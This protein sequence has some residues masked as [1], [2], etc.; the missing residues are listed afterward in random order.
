VQLGSGILPSAVTVRRG[1]SGQLALTFSDGG[2]LTLN[3]QYTNV[4]AANTAGQVEQVVFA[5]GTVWD[6]AQL[7]VL[8]VTGGSGVDA[9]N[10]FD[11]ADV[12]VGG[13]GN[14]NM[15]GVA[16]DDIYEGGAGTDTLTDS[17]TTSNE[18]YRYSLG[19]GA[20]TVSDSGG[21]DTVQLG[22][23]ILPSA[24]TVRRGTSGQLALTFS[25]GGI[26]TLNSQYSNVGVANTA[27]QIEQVVFADGTVW[28][29]AQLRVLAVAG[30]SAVDALHGFDGAD[31]LTG[32]ASN[33][34][35]QGYAGNDMLDGGAGNDTMTGGAGDDTYIV[36]ST[37]DTTT[38]SASA[39]TD[40]VISSVT[41]TSGLAAN[42]ENLTLSGANAI[43]GTGNALA[44]TLIGNAAA[45]TL[46]GLEGADV[47][48][49][50]AGNDT[51]NDTSTTSNDTYRFGIGYGLDTITDAG[52]TD[53]VVFGEG[54]TADQISFAASGSHLLVSVAG[55]ADVL[56]VSNWYASTA[57]RIEEFRLSDGTLLSADLIPT[58]NSTTAT[59]TSQSVTPG[60]T[61]VSAA[62]I[63]TASGGAI[64]LAT[65]PLGRL[66]A[67][68]VRNAVGDVAAGAAS[69]QLVGIPG[70]WNVSLQPS[71]QPTARGW[72]G[73][74][75]TTLPVANGP[76][77]AAA[78]GAGA[79]AAHVNAQMLT[80]AMASFDVQ[81][82]GQV[83]SSSGVGV[84]PQWEVL[85]ASAL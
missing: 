78:P 80:H 17:S 48:D 76:S 52:G 18:I 54:I 19:E 63:R 83:E 4:G 3:S 82:A 47:Y 16:G 49:G 29:Q 50:G 39:G 57:N 85:T 58:T 8:A 9:L 30:G 81:A 62:V 7:R 35:L 5:D 79:L 31:V 71:H 23:G 25:D 44:N 11:G 56:T 10:G 34:T 20:D 77:A 42:L 33:D 21:V 70:V 26:L 28:D 72:L 38:E 27:G 24:V 75:R 13:A 73:Q 65:G 74:I 84:R 68:V 43:N 53:S 60:G 67:S 37:S 61:N 32:G 46:S 69:R 55:Q 66:V 64:P 6:Q 59:A 2:I 45:N 51:L 22:S 1:T 14:D 15:Q 12:L 40:T 41:L 36:D